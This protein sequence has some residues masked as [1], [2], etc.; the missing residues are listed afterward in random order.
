VVFEGVQEAPTFLRG[1][2]GAQSTIVPSAD[3][4]LGI[5]HKGDML[6]TFLVVRADRRVLRTCRS[7]GPRCNA[8]AT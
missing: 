1:E 8:A 6:R 2:T 5:T 7:R 3:L 4:V